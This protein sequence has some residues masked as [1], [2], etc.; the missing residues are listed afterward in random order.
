MIM[1]GLDNY[2]S[3]EPIH[4]VYMDKDGRQYESVSKFI[5]R[6]YEAF[7]A[8]LMSKMVAKSTG[9]NAED[10][11]A[12]WKRY[13]TERADEGT[14]IHS[15]LEM[16]QKT[17]Q[18]LPE[19]EYLRPAIISIVSEYNYAYKSFQEQCLYDT[20][21]LIAG[22]CDNLLLYS[23]HPNSVVD[24]SDYKT[25]LKGLR[26]VDIDKKGARV[27]KFL[28]EPL[29]HLIDSKLNRY[30]LQLSIYAYLLQKKTG[31]RIGKLDI[32]YINPLNPMEH[33]SIP[34]QYMKMEVEAMFFE[35]KLQD[36]QVNQPTNEHTDAFVLE[37]EI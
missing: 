24:V 17:M 12:E 34:V 26:Q 18:I 6:F 15:A 28:K 3:L 37:P 36:S 29:S 1:P 31:R 21:N 35:K 16:Y 32:R 33:Y 23:S 22:T 13:G 5:S 27:H 11:A 7:D 20:E 19:N 25:N 9:G 4:H 2:V 30:A 14:K 10:I 8:Q